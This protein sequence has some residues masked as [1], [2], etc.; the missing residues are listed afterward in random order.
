MRYK[1]TSAVY[2]LLEKDGKYCTLRRKNTGYA[3]GL[4]TPPAGHVE[5]NESI[6]EAVCRETMEEAGVVVL[7]E[8]LE[9]I[10]VSDCAPGDNPGGGYLNFYFKVRSYDGEIVNNEPEKASEIVWVNPDNLPLDLIDHIAAALT[11]IGA[12]KSYSSFGW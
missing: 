3:D 6:E 5:E 8:N 2:I 4:L 12:G 7:R 9:L 10:H 11:A 1:H